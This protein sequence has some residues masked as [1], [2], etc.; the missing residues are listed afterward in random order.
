MLTGRPNTV[1]PDDAVNDRGWV[2]A[3]AL[4]VSSHADDS[5]ATAKRPSV[6]V[7]L[8]PVED[9]RITNPRPAFDPYA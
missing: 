2:G 8:W 9:Q 1:L 4:K 7:G 5:S 3:N 6:N